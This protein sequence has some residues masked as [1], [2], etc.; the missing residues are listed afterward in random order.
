MKIRDRLLNKTV[1][2]KRN[3]PTTDSTG[4]CSNNEVSIYTEVKCRITTNKPNG[5]IGLKE[6]GNL[7]NSTYIGFILPD[8]T[9][10]PGDFL[11]DSTIKYRIDD[12]NDIPGGL[13]DHHYELN[14]S[15]SE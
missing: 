8:Y 4:D 9:I 13:T 1:T 10:K 3:S 12:V 11:Y 14:L 6:V 2:I 7:Q 15:R 5:N